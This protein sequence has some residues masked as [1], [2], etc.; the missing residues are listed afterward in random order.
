[1]DFEKLA[2]YLDG[3]T[4]IANA[5]LLAKDALLQSLLIELSLIH[6]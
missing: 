3:K 6:I 5:E 4:G 2:G 1:M